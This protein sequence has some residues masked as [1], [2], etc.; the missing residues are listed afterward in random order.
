MLFCIVST[1]AH[2]K[3][4]FWPDLCS[5]PTLIVENKTALEKA[6]WLQKFSADELNETEYILTPKQVLKIDLT[7]QTE[8]ERSALM[9]FNDSNALNV[10]Y[11]CENIDYP[12][13]DLDGAEVTYKNNPARHHKLWMQNTFTGPNM[14]QLEYRDA[15]MKLLKTQHLRI[16][17]QKTLSLVENEIAWSFLTVSATNRLVSYLLDENGS[18]AP[19][20]AVPHVSNPAT[21]GAY[22][23]LNSRAGNDDSFVVKITDLKLAEKARYYAAHPESEKIVFATVQKDHQGFNRNMSLK[24][25]PLWSWSASEV[26]GFGDFGS[27]AC[28]GQPQELEDR[29][30]QWIEGIGRICFWNYRIKKELTP[31]E[32]SGRLAKNRTKP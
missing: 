6:V 27:T 18:S 8:T 19:Y 14:V 25:K 21:D 7:K 24:T 26:T 9:Y 3:V 32:V 4:L 2:A 15:A 11:N 16:D 20:K 22:F 30:D 1:K 5:A 23:L 29:V 31:T 28:N 13:T 10:Q 12:A 17:S